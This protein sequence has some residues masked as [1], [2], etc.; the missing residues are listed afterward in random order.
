MK[1]NITIE[2]AEK[3]L[4]GT[5]D[6]EEGKDLGDAVYELAHDLYRKNIQKIEEKYT[7]VDENGEPAKTSNSDGVVGELWYDESYETFFEKVYENLINFLTAK[8]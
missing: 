4:L 6:T 3:M 5:L 7:I 8:A 1:E 2:Q